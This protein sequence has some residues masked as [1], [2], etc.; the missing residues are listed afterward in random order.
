MRIPVP[1][2]RLVAFTLV[3]AVLT[4]VVAGGLAFPIPGLTGPGDGGTVTDRTPAG[5]SNAAADAP[6]PNQDFT[7]AVQTRSGDGDGDDE[8]Y[9]DDHDD[10]EEDER[11]GE[12]HED[13]EREDGDD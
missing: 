12:A 11:E 7:P 3:G 4:A 8:R 9:E 13:D 6:T 1:N 2:D 5:P 10:R